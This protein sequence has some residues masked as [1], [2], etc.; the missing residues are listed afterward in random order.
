MRLWQ[1]A[2]KWNT[3]AAQ[4]RRQMQP[5]DMHLDN[6]ARRATASNSAA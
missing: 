5:I 2:Q 4:E 1:V 3:K 6:L